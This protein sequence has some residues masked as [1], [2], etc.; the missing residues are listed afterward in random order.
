MRHSKLFLFWLLLMAAA[1]ISARSVPTI[2]SDK[3]AEASRQQVVWQGRVCTLSTLADDFLQSVYGKSRYKGLSAVQVVYG[4]LLR[5]DAWKDEA[6]IHVADADLR[7]QLNIEGEY[8]RFSDLF[9]DTLGYR[10]HQLGSDLPE[11]MRQLVRESEAAIDLDEKVGL[12]IM[13]TKGQL[14]QPRPENMKR[15]SPLQVEAEIL[16]NQTPS[17]VMLLSAVCMSAI[18]IMTA[19]RYS[20]RRKHKPQPQ[21]S[22]EA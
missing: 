13:L 7:R 19:I 16:Y 5:P 21:V 20:N 6:M 10:L 1:N 14:I 4:W 3:A 18:V 22:P 12:I 11:R 15:L 2:N 17:W 9:D 8:A